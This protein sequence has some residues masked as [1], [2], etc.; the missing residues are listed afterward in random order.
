MLTQKIRQQLTKRFFFRFGRYYFLGR[1][2]QYCPLSYFQVSLRVQIVYLP[3]VFLSLSVRCMDASY[4]LHNRKY[5]NQCKLMWST[6]SFVFSFLFTLVHLVMRDFYCHFS[7]VSLTINHFSNSLFPPYHKFSC[8]WYSQQK[9]F[10]I[11][12]YRC[13]KRMGVCDGKRKQL[14]NVFYLRSSSSCEK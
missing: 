9:L 6:S 2:I 12:D 4:F 8:S 13:T 1:N 3:F 7:C 14:A 10:S 11:V 5:L